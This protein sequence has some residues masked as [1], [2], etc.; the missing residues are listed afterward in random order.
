MIMAFFIFLLLISSQLVLIDACHRREREALMSFKSNMADPSNRLSSWKGRNCC[1]WY[2]INCS[3]T[4]HVTVIDLRN[5]E[6]NN[7]ILDMNSQPLS[8]SS[9]PSTALVGTISPSLFSLTHLTY[10]DL[11]FNNF[12]FSKVPLGFSNLSALT[13]LNLSNVM[14][15]DSI[16]TQFSNLTSLVEL[17]LS[18]ASVVVD[19][20]SA[21]PSLSSTVTVHLGSLYAYIDRGR[22]YASDLKWL[23]GLKNLRKLQLSGVD[24]SQ[25]SPSVLWAKPISNLTRLRLLDLSNCRI[26]GEIPVEQLLFLTRLSKLYMSFNFLATKIPTKLAN[27]TYLRVLD[28]TR[29][30]LQGHI[31]YLPQLKIL[32]LGN[33][34][35]LTVDLHSMFA[36][37]WPRLES[38][39]ISST[40]VIGSIPPTIGNTTSLVEFVAYN[41][42]I[43]GQIPTPMMN[44]SRLEYLSLDMNYM[45]G[46][47]SSSISNLKSLQF[48]SLMQN[49]FHGPIPETICTISSLWYLALAINSFTGNLPDC[50]GQL[51]DLSYLVVN[52]NNMNGS[53]P[54]LSS[55]FRNSTPYMLYLSYSGLTVKVDQQPFPPTFQPQLLSLDSCNIG[56]TIPSWLFNLPNLGY[57]D[58]SFNT[59]Q[60]VIPPNIKLKSSFMQT[61]LRLRRNL[62]QGSI[63]RWLRNIQ[64]LD[65][66]ENNFTGSI[67]SEVGQGNIRYLKLSDNRISGR[68]PFSLCQENNELMLLDLSNNNL[69]GTVPTSFG[70]CRSL[71]YLNLGSNNLTGGIPGELQQARGLRFLDISGN[72]FDGLF[73]SVVHKFEKIM[74]INMGNNKFSGEIPQF[75]GDLEDLRLLELEYNF[76][77][78]S[79]P[80]EIFGLEN[81]QFIGFSNN[82]LSGPIPD[83]LSGLKTIINR[84]K[85]GDLLGFIVS[86]GYI[87]VKVDMVA[88]GLLLQFNVVRTYHNGMDLS[89]NNLTGNI[90]SELGILKG[91]YALNLSHNGLSGNIP[92][93]IGNMSLLESLDLGYNNLSGEIPSSLTRL[94][95]ITTL[96]LAYNNLSGKISTSPHFDTLS[97]DG[98]AYIGN[99][100]L[101]GA[102][103]GIDCDDDDDF[104]TSESSDGSENQSGEWRILLA[105]VFA[106]Y[107]TGFWGLFGVVYLVNKRWREAYWEI[108]DRIVA[109]ITRCS[110]S[111]LSFISDLL[112]RD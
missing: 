81:L 56:G 105:V 27:L 80:E 26:S 29:S 68:I 4:L 67:P 102:P 9:V 75:I 15:E 112:N 34:S 35:D 43:Q 47:I 25:V 60:G 37:P 21:Y 46:E 32:Y 38:I 54:S 36:V 76:F 59:L 97:R 12:S 83:K 63:P 17:D 16:T 108:V 6:P 73:P 111:R 5:P 104:P 20:S 64:I 62:L 50:L 78:G 94:D 19:Y 101:C 13:Y 2:G 93:T 48:L 91:L 98:L 49:S 23:Q 31:P 71:V 89:C 100:F 85:D 53:I 55:F 103:D 110:K 99:R 8:T 3:D 41:S 1:S 90:P 33:N 28:L 11:S 109:E 58:L 22:L 65:L 7:L 86:K 44:L 52:S 82:Q 40:H 57:L 51:R 61:T 72:Q 24:L 18:C 92:S 30:N 14:F 70:N 87:G 96:N 66:S 95:S 69:F 79:I 88:K 74:V 106:G 45:S 39:D 107:V 77:N 10:L 84:P 42:F